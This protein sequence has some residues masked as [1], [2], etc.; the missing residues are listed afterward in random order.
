MIAVGCICFHK[1]LWVKK[2][3]ELE[4]FTK[5][6]KKKIRNKINKPRTV[7]KTEM[8]FFVVLL[9]VFEI[10]LMVEGIKGCR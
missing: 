6:E 5:K 8:I 4:N 9:I 1:L 2:L 7:F 10:G 3:R